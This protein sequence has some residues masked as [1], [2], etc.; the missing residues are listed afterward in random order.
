MYL[1]S[2]LQDRRVEC[3]R[4]EPRHA[5]AALPATELD[6]FRPAVVPGPPMLGLKWLM[7]LKGLEPEFN[8]FLL[9]YGEDP[10]DSYGQS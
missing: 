5:R 8:Q 4:D 9:V 7:A 2:E 10:A 1:E 6:E 3:A